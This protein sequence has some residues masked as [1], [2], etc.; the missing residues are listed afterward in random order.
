MGGVVVNAV[1]APLLK[2][3]DLAAAGKGALDRDLVVA[4]LEAAGVRVRT[5]AVDALLAEVGEHAERVA[6][7]K[8]ERRTLKA[9]G[10]PTYDLPLL[11]EGV[12]L[13]GLYRLAEDLCRQGMA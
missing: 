3:A 12:D 6:L 10:H 1:R 2:Q 9:L 8:R 13:G 4:G 7:E 5:G 11:A